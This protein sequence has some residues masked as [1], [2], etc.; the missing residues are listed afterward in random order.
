VICTSGNCVLY[1]GSVNVEG[2]NLRPRSPQQTA[3]KLPHQ[4]TPDHG[5]SVTNRHAGK[6]DTVQRDRS[7]RRERPLFE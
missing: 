4:P 5:N 2:E 3:G 1:A 7:N 6:A